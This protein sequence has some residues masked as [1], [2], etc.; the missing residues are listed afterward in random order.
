MSKA[1]KALDWEKQLELCIDQKKAKELYNQKK[2]K[3]IETCTMCGEFC[4][5]K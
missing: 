1:R 5:L 4:S 2:V 3:D